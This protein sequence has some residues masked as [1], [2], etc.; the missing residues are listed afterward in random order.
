MECS[1][2]LFVTIKAHYE[3]IE[4][5]CSREALKPSKKNPKMYLRS[6]FIQILFFVYKTPKIYYKD[7]LDKIQFLQY[8]PFFT[9]SFSDT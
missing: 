6:R 4:L 5:N 3:S 1:S 9:I 2:Q 8:E 7:N